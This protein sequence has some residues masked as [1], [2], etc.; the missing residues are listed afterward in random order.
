MGCSVSFRASAILSV[1]YIRALPKVSQEQVFAYC[2]QG[3]CNAT[4]VDKFCDSTLPETS[5]LRSTV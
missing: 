1:A 3:S 5:G 2:I 4:E